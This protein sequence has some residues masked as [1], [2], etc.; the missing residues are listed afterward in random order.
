MRG[1]DGLGLPDSNICEQAQ[2]LKKYRGREMGAGPCRI[3]VRIQLN[4]ICTDQVQSS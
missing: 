2:K 4:Q 1:S 3:A